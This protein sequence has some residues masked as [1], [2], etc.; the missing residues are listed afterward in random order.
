MDRNE[1]WI[2]QMRRS[3]SPPR[4]ARSMT[5]DIIFNASSLDLV[6]ASEW[7][8]FFYDSEKNVDL[9]V[10]ECVSEGE[11]VGLDCWNADNTRCDLVLFN[12]IYW[13]PNWD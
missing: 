4:Q 2:T 7:E 9:E 12:N 6:Y 3:C 11:P 1:E 8:E 5:M 10:D 13:S